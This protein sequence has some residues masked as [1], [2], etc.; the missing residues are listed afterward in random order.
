MRIFGID[1]GLTATGWGLIE[2]EGNSLRFRDCGTVCVPQTLPLSQ[3]LARLLECLSGIVSLCSPD[4]VA[5]EAVFLGNNP[6]SAFALGQARTVALLATVGR[7]CVEYA[8]RTVKR[9]VSTSGA[10]DKQQTRLMMA[11]LFSESRKSLDKASEH[12]I[13]A[14]AVATCHALNLASKNLQEISQEIPQKI[15][16][17]ISQKISIAKPTTTSAAKEEAAAT[18]RER[19]L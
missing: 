11:R 1:P 4:E 2:R 13:D 3:R 16:Q 12:A 10:I 15:S 18:T 9:A 19:V 14:L 8:P 5:L 17:E 7:P 6:R